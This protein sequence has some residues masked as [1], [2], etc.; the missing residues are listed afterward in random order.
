MNMAS[1]TACRNR[2]MVYGHRRFVIA[3]ANMPVMRMGRICVKYMS[4]PW[5]DFGLCYVLGYG[6]IV[7]FLNNCS[8]TILGFSSSYTT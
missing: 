7:V 6:P 1:T 5:K 3:T 8:L 4:I 2:D